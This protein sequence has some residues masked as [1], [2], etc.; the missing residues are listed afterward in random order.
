MSYQQGHWYR[1]G[2]STG[3]DTVVCIAFDFILPVLGVVGTNTRLVRCVQCSFANTLQPN[4][5]DVRLNLGVACMA[6]GQ[7]KPHFWWGS[8]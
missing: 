2:A 3:Q 4:N 8:I 6:L 1:R 7:E 5:L